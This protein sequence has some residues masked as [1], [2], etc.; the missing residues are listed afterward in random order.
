MG[1]YYVKRIISAIG[2]IL[3]IATVTFIIM[4]VIPGGPFTR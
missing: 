1:N 4:K 3:I 2:T